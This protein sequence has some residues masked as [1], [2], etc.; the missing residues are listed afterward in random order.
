MNSECQALVSKL[1]IPRSTG[2]MILP[3]NALSYHI[4]R[5]SGNSV[6]AGRRSFRLKLR[7]PLNQFNLIGFSVSFESDYVN[8]PL[9]LELAHIPPLAADRT[10][11]DPLIIAGGI[12]ITY[13]PEPITDFVDIFVVGEGEIT[14]HHL[15][16][17]ISSWSRT[18]AS[19]EDLL[20][21]V[22]TVPGFYVPNFYHVDYRDDGTIERTRA[23]AN[24]PEKVRA[25]A[26]ANLDDVATCTQIHTPKHRIF[27]RPSH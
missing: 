23:E 13:N 26:V 25:S 15:M 5:Y 11:R 18:G 24:A 14:I 2:A 6:K 1:S 21:S 16:D 3:A 10:D 27:Q 12:N 22:T 9:A 17:C 4:F 20:R 8:I 19:K 7:T